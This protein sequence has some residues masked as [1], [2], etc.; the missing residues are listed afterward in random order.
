MEKIRIILVEDNKDHSSLVSDALRQEGF[1]VDEVASSVEFFQAL[2]DNHFDILI[3]DIG[4][5]DFSGFSILEY[6]QK[7]KL[8]NNMG[9]VV[10]TA[11]GSR[12][13][14]IR[15]YELGADLY[16]LKPVD[17]QELCLAV[18]NLS[19]RLS[20]CEPPDKQISGWSL[21]KANWLLLS[22]SGASC[23][24]S[25]K[26]VELLTRLSSAECEVVNKYELACSLGYLEDEHGKRA[27][28][29]VVLRLRRKLAQAGCSNVPIK[30]V[31]GIGYTFS[32]Q[33]VIR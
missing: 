19:N 20:V 18:T 27:L 4:L 16:I 14:R 12:E 5:P 32:A 3:L 8:Y 28:E 29:S 30:T 6:L 9:I 1:K 15:G 26:E 22:P 21:D 25:A 31:H 10:L 33:L 13:D 24:L 23:K 7:N 17:I 2:V 11:F